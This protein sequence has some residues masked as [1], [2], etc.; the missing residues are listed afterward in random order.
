MYNNKSVDWFCLNKDQNI[1]IEK[2]NELKKRTCVFDY[3][4]LR[5]WYQLWW[6]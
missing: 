2:K 1:E 3:P 5:C 6:R 4:S